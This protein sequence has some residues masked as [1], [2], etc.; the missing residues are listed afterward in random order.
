MLCCKSASHLLD[1]AIIIILLPG[2]TCRRFE[3]VYSS[4]HE[5]K[6]TWTAA[7]ASVACAELCFKDLR[8]QCCLDEIACVA[9]E[10]GNLKVLEWARLRDCDFIPAM[11][12]PAFPQGHI[13]VLKW[14]AEHDLD[15][16][17]PALT[18]V[19]AENGHSNVLEF[20]WKQNREFHDYSAER[21]AACGQVSVLS[22]MKGRNMLE[23]ETTLESL[24]IEAIRNEQINVLDWLNGEHYDL[25]PSLVILAIKVEK[26]KVL[27]WAKAR[28]VQWDASACAAAA[29]YGNLSVL[30]WLRE[31]GCPWDVYAI[32]AA[33]RN[34]HDHVAEWAVEN[35]CP[36]E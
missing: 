6:T 1:R 9:I 30:Q 20:L 24:W 14:A 8:F 27:L 28:N 19:A 10:M 23:Q 26:I 22:W 18:A 32:E 7:A 35:G 5:R 3:E 34:G 16:F 15:W 33:R 13:G 11:F 2:T 4:K 31:N 36:Q 21:A 29:L 25:Y 12:F 17:D